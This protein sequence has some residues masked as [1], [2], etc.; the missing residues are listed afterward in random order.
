MKS[1]APSNVLRKWF[2]HDP[3]KWKQFVKKYSE[4]INDS[5]P[6]AELRSDILKHRNVTLLFSA[7]DE[8]YNQAKALQEILA[9]L[10]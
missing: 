4:E 2:N 5:A 7:K 6:L 10:M 9:S 1:I 3:E 8:Q